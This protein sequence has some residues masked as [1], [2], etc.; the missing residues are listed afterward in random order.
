MRLPVREKELCL[1]TLA[2]S[3]ASIVSR[4]RL[5]LWSSCVRMYMELF[6]SIQPL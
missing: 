2:E 4:F 3:W 5:P 1:P 6:D